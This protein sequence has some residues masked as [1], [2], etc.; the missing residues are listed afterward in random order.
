M[1]RDEVLTFAPILD[2]IINQHEL[3]IDAELLTAAP[4][5][6]IVANVAIGTNNFDP[7]AM[8]RAG[9]WGT[10]V[11]YAFV[12]ATADHTLALLLAV[13]RRITDAHTYCL[14]GQWPKDGFQPGVWDGLL[15]RGRTLGI[16]GFGK[17]GRAV[18]D[19][20]RGFGLKVIHANAFS[21]D[22]PGY[23]P[24]SELIAKADI[25]SLHVPLT[26]QTQHL[27]DREMILQLRAGSILLNVARGGLVDEEALADAIES[28]HVY[29]AGLDVAEHEPEL[30]A[31]L[32]QTGRV[33]F[34]P[35]IGGGT[36]ESRAAA[37]RCAANDV[38]RVLQNHPPDN[39]VFKPE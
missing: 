34:T 22:A 29:G 3:T 26:K 8:Q 18:A 16:I 1:S 39:P 35:H 25:V 7:D 14:S 12:D 9:I 31:R 17:I 5:L 37:R 24:M 4:A 10:N 19:R 32:Q 13:V 20:A 33:V 23:V 15:L 36:L 6:K 28:G 2:A 27:I 11:P 38:A 30:N 21:Q